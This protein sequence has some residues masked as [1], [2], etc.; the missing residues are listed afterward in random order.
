M[1]QILYKAFIFNYKLLV[2]GNLNKHY[3]YDEILDG[4]IK[5]KF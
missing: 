3:K 5:I 4:K 2:F 1:D